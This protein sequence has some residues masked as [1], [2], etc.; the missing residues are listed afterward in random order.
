MGDCS[1]VHSDV[2][3]ITEIQEPFS[4]E[5]GAVVG[6]DGIGDPEEENNILD[7]AHSLTR[8]NFSQGHCLDPL[9]ELV[10][11]DKQ[12]GQAFERF[13]EGAHKI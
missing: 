9:C 11:H 4:Y 5:H 13:L 10:N 6:D 3:V 2:V 8:A 1:P 7:K 12:V